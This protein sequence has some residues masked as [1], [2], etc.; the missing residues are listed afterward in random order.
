MSAVQNLPDLQK[1]SDRLCAISREQ[2]ANPHTSI[3]WPESIPEDGWCTSPELVSLYGTPTWD[4]LDEAQQKR[5][6]FFECVNFFCINIHGEKALL[7]GLTHRLYA[8]EHTAHSAYL[9]HFVDEENKHMLY[10]G[11]FCSR[12]AGK[13]Y[14]D[15]KLA[16]PGAEPP[17]K[18]T[19]F[20]FFVKVAVFEEL[21]DAYNQRMGDDERLVPVVRRINEMHH[22]DEVRHLAFGRTLVQHLFNDLRA[23]WSDEEL[24]AMRAYI[25]DY[26]RSTWREYYNPDVYRDAGIA[27]AYKVQR[28]AL[29]SEATRA[30]RREVSKKCVRWLMD[31]GFFTEEPAQ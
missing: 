24:A 17:P 15:R 29:A 21:V 7:E 13:I 16:L 5:L 22:R 23:S 4:A 28:A 6:A 11:T 20:L 19:D 9:H 8:R 25:A 12:Y 2:F 1:L 27:D 30:H 14:P 26:I 10:F 31:I 18:V 3:E